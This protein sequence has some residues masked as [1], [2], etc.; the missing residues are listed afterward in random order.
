MATCSCG[1]KSENQN[2][3]I[4]FSQE[5]LTMQAEESNSSIMVT[6]SLEWSASSDQ[7]WCSMTPVNGQSGETSL[8][9]D[10]SGNNTG[11]SRTAVLTFKSGECSKEYTVVQPALEI[12]QN[13]EIQFS[14]ESLALQAEE[15]NSSI[16]VTSSVEWSVSSGQDWCS[17][18]P[19]NGQSGETSL[20]ID[21]SDNYTGV[22]RT[23]VLTFESG[24]CSEEYTVVQSAFEINPPLSGYTLVWNDEFSAS[25]N[26]RKTLAKQSKWQ[27]EEGHGDNGWG[28]NELQNYV[29]GFAGTDT[30]AFMSN[31]TLK[32]VA[33]KHGSEVISARMN[34]KESWLYGYFEARLKLP[35]GR[36]TW[37][38][39][40]ML[41][42]NFVFWPDDGEI[43]IMEEVG[44]NPNWV[45]SAIHCKAYYHSIGTQKTGEKFVS[46]AES[47]FHV[48]AVEWTPDY[49]RGYVDGEYYFEF[50]NDKAGNRDTWPFN[51]PF[52][53]KLNLAWG[54]NWGGAQG[55][56]ESILPATYEIDYVRVF[57][58][59]NNE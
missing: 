26:G 4:R 10:V 59:I 30:C 40:W 8:R 28:N 12:S 6:S 47:D 36:G 25:S 29:P 41:P 16:L 44:F 23:A 39:F 38:A 13:C 56:D 5:N 46:S 31:G 48:Y 43:D 21:V 37:P 27:F 19:V 17:I 57:Q 52:Y 20:K 7:N 18:T 54:G 22:S 49:I 33:Q 58:R 3:E 45:S 2:C 15:S 51:A 55:V 24:E 32:I 53:L 42:R 34:T 1:E 9:I 14:P 50:L 11:L 35:G